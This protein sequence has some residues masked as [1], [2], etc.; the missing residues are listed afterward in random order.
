VS[1]LTV[2]TAVGITKRRS[3]IDARA[4]AVTAQG[5]ADWSA[6]TVV[7]YVPYWEQPAAIAEALREPGLVTTAAPW[8]YSP[9][10]AGG[11]VLQHRG[12][13]D[14]G[15]HVVRALRERGL[16]V[17]PTIANHHRGEWDYEVVPELIAD[18]AT[19]EAH[20]RNLV[21]LIDARDFDGIVIDY[22][23]LG[24]RDRDN[25]TAFITALGAALHADGR[26]LAVALHAQTTDEGDGGHNVAQD[27]RAIG[28]AADEVHLMTYDLHYDESDP[29]PVAP[30]PWVV[31]VLDYATGRIPSDKLVLGV[32]LFGYDW[33]HGDIADDVQLREVARRIK[34]NDGEHGWDRRAASPWFRYARD[35][36][37][38]IIWYEDAASVEAKLALVA[39]YDLAGA[40]FWR[41]GGV[42][43]HIW[44]VAE[45]T[46]R[47]AM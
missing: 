35:G 43:E 31:D 27:Y 39:R 22:E 42:P 45:Q 7:G 4:S 11:V 28:R 23:L 14:A 29:G 38:R 40:F 6:L 10:A 1:A 24:A 19:R 3:P 30:L 2:V 18:P 37:S 36:V 5:P 9:T 25:F 15:D 46:L 13:T 20:V 32:G 33:G 44:R 8:W 17:M 26:R 21:N 41:L 16:R 47:P 12:H 34:A